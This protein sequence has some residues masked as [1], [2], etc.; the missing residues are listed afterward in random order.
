VCTTLV[1]RNLGNNAG[2]SSTFLAP[3]NIWHTRKK[4]KNPDRQEQVRQQTCGEARTTVCCDRPSHASSCRNEKTRHVESGCRISLVCNLRTRLSEAILRRPPVARAN[5]GRIAGMSCREGGF[6]PASHFR[7]NWERFG[8][9]VRLEGL[10]PAALPSE[11]YSFPW[12]V[13]IDT[14]LLGRGFAELGSNRNIS[15]MG[16]HAMLLRCD[17]AC[18]AR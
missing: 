14:E 12:K 6:S 9:A 16:M 4:E 8:D 1:C 2:R 11:S 5:L 3:C 18:L 10:H 15:R 13:V 7:P 17:P